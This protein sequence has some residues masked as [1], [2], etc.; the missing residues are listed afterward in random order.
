MATWSGQRRAARSKN[1]WRNTGSMARAG[2]VWRV[3]RLARFRV[4]VAA[5][6]AG[7][8]GG[9]GAARIRRAAPC[10]Q[11]GGLPG[12]LLGLVALGRS[13][14]RLGCGAGVAFEDLGHLPGTVRVAVGGVLELL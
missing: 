5:V 3:L 8:D 7:W 12:A 10:G 14:G 2:A 11:G 1:S 9:S 6:P 4:M 13:V